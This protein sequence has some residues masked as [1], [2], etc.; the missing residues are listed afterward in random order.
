VVRA[1]KKV[2][3]NHVYQMRKTSEKQAAAKIGDWYGR[4]PAVPVPAFRG[5]GY[6]STARH[7]AF[8]KIN[9]TRATA[10]CPRYGI[11]HP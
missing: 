3:D 4:I 8:H 10:F 5:K 7:P 1:R 11:I 2:F 9:I 6:F